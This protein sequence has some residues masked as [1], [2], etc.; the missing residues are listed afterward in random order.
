MR[1]NRSFYLTALTILA[2]GLAGCGRDATG[3][4]GDNG[5]P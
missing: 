1:F 2:L 4:N 3:P 5:P